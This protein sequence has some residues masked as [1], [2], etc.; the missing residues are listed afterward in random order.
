VTRTWPYNPVA[1]SLATDSTIWSVGPFLNEGHKVV[2]ANV[3]RHY[4]PTGQLLTSTI[5]RSVRK[6]TGGLYNVAET[7]SLM[8]S[9]DRVGWLTMT[10]QYL[11]FSLDGAQLPG[12]YSCPNG[13]TSIIHNSGV[14]LSVS[15]DLLVGGKMPTGLSQFELDRTTNAWKP[16]LMPPDSGNTQMLLGFDGLTLVTWVSSSGSH[17]IRRYTWADAASHNGGQ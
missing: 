11:E 14:A 6:S 15:N 7:S 5:I 13:S 17:W 9:N 2:Y 4:T 1:V 10:C 3:L 16:V 8:T 12:S